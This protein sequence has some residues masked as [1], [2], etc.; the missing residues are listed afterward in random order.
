MIRKH[1]RKNKMFTLL[2]VIEEGG[3]A[4]ST[5][6]SFFRISYIKVSPCPEKYTGKLKF[7]RK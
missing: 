3:G 6:H 7:V 2:V 4:I 1:D 5:D